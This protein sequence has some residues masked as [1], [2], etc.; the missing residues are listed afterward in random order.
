MENLIATSTPTTCP[1]MFPERLELSVMTKW[2]QYPWKSFKILKLFH[3]YCIHFVITDSSKRSG[4]IWGQVVGVDV[5]IKFSI[6]SDELQLMRFGNYTYFFV[7][8]SYGSL[9]SSFSLF[10]FLFRC[11]IE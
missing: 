1:H 9:S 6:V 8:F 2:M 11:L 10:C 5:A 7:Q 3:G 4:N